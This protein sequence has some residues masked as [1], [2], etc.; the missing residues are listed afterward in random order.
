MP[1]VRRGRPRKVRVSKDA[2]W[3]REQR[4]AGNSPGATCPRCGKKVSGRLDTQHNDGNPGNAAPANKRK[5]CRSCHVSIDNSL[6]RHV[7][8]AK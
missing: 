8:G 5:L 4:K 1:R 3:K 7:K 6:R 2:H